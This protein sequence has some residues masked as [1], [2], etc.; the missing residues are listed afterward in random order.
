VR[1]KVRYLESLGEERERARQSE[2]NRH[3]RILGV[4][5]LRRWDIL[6]LDWCGRWIY[7]GLSWDDAR[8]DVLIYAWEK[9]SERV[10]LM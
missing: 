6:R 9:D 3:C 5:G 2:R 7:L 8:Y 1:L 4:H 10:R